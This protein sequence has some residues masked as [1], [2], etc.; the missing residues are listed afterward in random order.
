M[1]N[2]LNQRKRITDL[3]CL[4]P[5]FLFILS[6]LLVRLHMTTMP[7][8]DIYWSESTDTTTLTDLFTWWK[9]AAII[10][11]GC[12]AVVLCIAGWFGKFLSFKKSRLY[13]PV[14][15]Y[16]VFV[17]LSL[18]T[19]GYKYFAI[20]GM[21]EHFE[22]TFVLLAYMVMVVFLV[23]AVD[24]ERRVAMLV[25]C[26]LGAACLLGLLGVTQA[27]GHDFFSTITGQKLITPNARLDSGMM[28]WDMIDLMGKTGQSIY[29][30]SFTA[31]EVYQTVYNINY[32][33]MYLILLIPVCAVLFLR[34]WTQEGGKNKAFAAVVLVL[35]GLLVYNFFA[36]NSASGYFGLVAALLAAIILFRKYLKQWIK[37]LLCLVIVAALVMGLLADRWLPEIKGLLGDA[38]ER[39]TEAIYADNAPDLQTSF[40]NAPAS[41]SVPVDR[42]V[43]QG[44][45]VRFGINGSDIVITRDPSQGAFIIT[46]GAGEQLFMRQM[47]DGSGKFEILDERFHDAAVLALQRGDDDATYVVVSTRHHDWRFRYDEEGFRYLNGVGKLTAIPEISNAG[48]WDASFGSY[49]GRIW[50][51]ALP[52]LKSYLI[53][54]AGADCFPFV[55]PQND[56]A[57]LYD[58]DPYGAN[59]TLVTDKAHNFYAQTWINTG[60][61]SLLAWLALVGLYLVGAVKS[62][63]KR[64]FETFSDLVNGGIFCGILGFLLVALFND[65]SVSTMPMFYTMLGTGLAIN[66]MSEPEN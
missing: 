32:V 55:Y 63:R 66:A 53:K 1:E 41:A 27:T 39:V 48:I 36:A 49:R 13:I 46:D 47:D 56:Y 29:A 4:L 28:S 17:L 10:G 44:D 62:F 24:S 22:G 43:A 60:L 20:H 14:L 19:S 42:V 57:A 50:N 7:M 5:A 33:P 35:F 6:I 15:V 16:A 11:A 21:S 45:T 8:T 65:G 34:L 30:F 37:P 3:A 51:D 12:L 25:C 26:A 31:G 9:S 23:N 59:M 64:G 40:D 61:P 58:M 2:G 18:V 38:L 52:M 54:G